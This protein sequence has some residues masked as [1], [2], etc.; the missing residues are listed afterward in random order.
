MGPLVMFVAIHFAL[1]CLVE[2]GIS[3][4]TPSFVNAFLDN[5]LRTLGLD[6]KTSRLIFE[7]TTQVTRIVV[8][9]SESREFAL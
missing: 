3:Y 8:S 2:C 4:Y 5:S 9:L 6:A 7:R 1:D